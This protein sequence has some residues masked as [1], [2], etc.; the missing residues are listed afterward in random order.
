MVASTTSST[1]ELPDDENHSLKVS[2]S[3]NL[4]SL[5]CSFPSTGSWKNWDEL[6][7][8]GQYMHLEWLCTSS[9][10]IS[11]LGTDP[12]TP[13]VS[14]PLFS[15][16]ELDFAFKLPI[17]FILASKLVTWQQSSNFYTPSLLPSIYWLH[18]ATRS[19]GD[20]MAWPLSIF[21]TWTWM[22]IMVAPSI[23]PSI[24][25][26]CFFPLKCSS[27]DTVSSLGTDPWT[28]T[29]N[30]CPWV[31][32]CPGNTAWQLELDLGLDFVSALHW[33]LSLIYIFI[34]VQYYFPCRSP[35]GLADLTLNTRT[36]GI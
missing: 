3:H 19:W 25:C 31:P 12:L 32:Q 33:Q 9:D 28:P 2:K 1:S 8:G 35:D 7:P 26:S 21:F 36:C 11:N 5:T 34:A 13:T 16:H 15:Y 17:G 20:Q 23:T 14:W 18:I 6:I 22:F 10:T 27:S 4:D 29:V 30:L 24:S